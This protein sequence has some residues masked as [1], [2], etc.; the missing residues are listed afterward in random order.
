MR[1]WKIAVVV[2]SVLLAVSVAG[3]VLMARQTRWI[4]A[5]LAEGQLGEM[6]M[7]ARQIRIGQS[8]AVLKRLDE[9]IPLMALQFER[10][11]SKYVSPDERIGVLWA[12]QRY[13]KDSPAMQPPPELKAIL[14]ALPPRPLTSCEAAA[15]KTQ[16]ATSVEHAT[17]GP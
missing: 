3:L 16:P 9:A 10:E 1:K 17:T 11:H 14:D 6:A 15:C 2:L 12:V 8:E 5:F 7:N 13:Y 4:M